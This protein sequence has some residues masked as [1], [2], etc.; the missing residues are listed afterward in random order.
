MSPLPS[1]VATLVAAAILTALV[2]ANAGAQAAGDTIR[3]TAPAFGIHRAVGVYVEQRSDT[4]VYHSVA[5]SARLVAVPLGAISRFEVNKGDEFASGPVL[6][7]AIAGFIVGA[8]A[9]TAVLEHNGFSVCG[10]CDVPDLGYYAAVGGGIVVGTVGALIGKAIRGGDYRTVKLS[11]VSA[12]AARSES[13]STVTIAP[14]W[15]PLVR[16]PGVTI[17]LRF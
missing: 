9:A 2:G 17:G 6:A 14:R 13:R 4:L 7:G 10:D 11:P 5:D 3:V 16:G 12:D 1:Q 15:D 8:V